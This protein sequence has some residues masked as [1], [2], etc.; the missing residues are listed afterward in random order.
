MTVN[1]RP[2][3]PG[4]GPAIAR[5]WLSAGTYHAELDPKHFQ[6]PA[7]SPPPQPTVAVFG[8]V[9]QSQAP[10]I[11]DGYASRWASRDR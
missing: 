6:V 8:A 11:K 4:D 10:Q 9:L 1:V 5:A 7:V 3:A 2:I